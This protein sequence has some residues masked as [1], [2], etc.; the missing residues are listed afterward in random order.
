QPTGCVVSYAA[1]SLPRG[2]LP[3]VIGRT[4]SPGHRVV[5][6]N[7]AALLRGEAAGARVPLD[8]YLPTRR[9]TGGNTPLQNGPLAVL[10]SGYPL[11]DLPTGFARHPG[12]LTGECTHATDGT[13]SADWLQVGGD[14]SH[15]PASAPAGLTGLH[16]MDYNVAQGDLTALATAQARAWLDSRTS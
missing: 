2:S 7:L 14:L 15:F 6:V 16:V 8:L 3:A 5:C 1:Y 11:P 4:A 9:L 13:V 10:L 12:A